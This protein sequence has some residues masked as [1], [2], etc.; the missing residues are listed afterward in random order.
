M[1][2]KR[3]LEENIDLHQ[4]LPEFKKIADE[5]QNLNFCIKDLFDNCK[6]N[7]KIPIAIKDIIHIKGEHTTFASKMTKNFIAPINATIVDKLQKNVLL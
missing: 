2:I 7:T 6:S 3:V 4:I 1:T 5:N